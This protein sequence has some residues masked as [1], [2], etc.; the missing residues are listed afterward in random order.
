MVM[1]PALAINLSILHS[2]SFM[3][4]VHIILCKGGC[5]PLDLLGRTSL[6]EV[7][8]TASLV[9]GQ[10][11]STKVVIASRPMKAVKARA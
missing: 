2:T 10:A 5:R 11:L 4:C 3:R 8:M 6:D 7:P 9:S 1:L